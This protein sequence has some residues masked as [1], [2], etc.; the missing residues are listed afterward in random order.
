MVKIVRISTEFNLFKLCNNYSEGETK[1]NVFSFANQLFRKEMTIF[2][3]DVKRNQLQQ[4]LSINN[5]LQK[6]FSYFRED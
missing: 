5:M 4:H 2:L 6:L 3:K 1:N